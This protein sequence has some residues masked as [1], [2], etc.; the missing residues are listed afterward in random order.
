MCLYC[1]YFT[2]VL[3]TVEVS[4]D[5]E[6]SLDRVCDPDEQAQTARIIKESRLSNLKGKSNYPLARYDVAF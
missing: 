4:V 2:P 6:K 3:P 5:L 1:V